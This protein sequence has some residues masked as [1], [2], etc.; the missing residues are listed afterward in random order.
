MNLWRAQDY[1]VTVCDPLTL[2]F[3]DQSLPSNTTDV[4]LVRDTWLPVTSG[5]LCDGP[6][7]AAKGNQAKITE[8][9]SIGSMKVPKRIL[10]YHA[11]Q[12]VAE[13]E[14]VTAKFDTGTKV[15]DLETPPD[16]R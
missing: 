10:N 6:A 7:A 14:T 4:E 13:I 11:G 16:S 3:I 5:A 8:W 1:Q 9:M 12:L 2:R 15:D